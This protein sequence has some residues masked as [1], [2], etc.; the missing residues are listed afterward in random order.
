MRAA[1]REARGCGRL[2]LLAARQ[3]AGL[4]Y[5]KRALNSRVEEKEIR[6]EDLSEEM[7]GTFDLY[8]SSVC[9]IMRLT[10][11][12]ICGAFALCAEAWRSWRRLSMPTTTDVRPW[13][14]MR[15]PG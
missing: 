2:E 15:A 7:V 6:V 10:R 14:S 4:R 3:Q 9:F 8:C 11:L 5:A 13:S 1:R 12:V